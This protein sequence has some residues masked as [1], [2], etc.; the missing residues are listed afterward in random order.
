[1]IMTMIGAAVGLGT[2]GAFPIGRARS[3][4]PPSSFLR[5]RLRGNWC[6]G[7]DGEICVGRHICRGTVG[8]FAAV[9]FRLVG[10]LDGSFSVPSLLPPGTTPL[11]SAGCC[12]YFL[13]QGALALGNVV[14]RRSIFPPDRGF[15][16]KLFGLELA[17]VA[18]VI[19][20]CAVV[21]V[22]GLRGGIERA[23]R[24]IMPGLFLILLVLMVGSLTLPGAEAG[25]TVR[26]KIE[27]ADLT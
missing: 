20:S 17:C 2:S 27:W 6:S 11:L 1:M 10:K 24:I 21:L 4:G 8:A 23:S 3:A 19:V 9:V 22:K 25:L 26:P 5:A 13:A 15:A 7:I 16:A 18:A 14:E 12:Y